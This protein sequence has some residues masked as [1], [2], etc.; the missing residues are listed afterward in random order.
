MPDELLWVDIREAKPNKLFPEELRESVRFLRYNQHIA[1]AECGKKAR[2]H[3]TMLCEFLA[4]SLGSFVLV[5][6]GLVHPPLT[7][8]CRDHPLAPAWPEPEPKLG[9]TPPE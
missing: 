2:I 6:S 4:K 5:D 1:C 7:P 9:T 8:V 3:W